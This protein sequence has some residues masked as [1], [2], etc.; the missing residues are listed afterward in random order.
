[1]ATARRDVERWKALAEPLLGRTDVFIYPFGA[2]PPPTSP[3]IR[4]LRDEGY[5][6]LC[7]IDVGP[8][9]R[10]EDGLAVMS[11]RHIDGLA[12][13]QQHAALRPLFDTRAVIDA[14]ARGL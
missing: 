2:Q 13:R 8:R 11:R 12:L 5:R 6:I 3:V 14:K 4:M 9:L 7:D 10:H 1:V